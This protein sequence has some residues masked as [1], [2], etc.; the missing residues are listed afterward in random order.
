MSEYAFGRYGWVLSLTFLA[1]GTSSWALA[2]ALRAHIQTR[3]GRVGVTFLIV[4]GLGQALAAVFDIRHDVLH[5]LA[6][7]LG[8]IGLPVAAI[9]ISVSL[10]GNPEWSP[11]KRRLLVMA[12]L[13]W[14]SVVLFAA[15]FVLLTVTFIQ[16]NGG[17]PAQ[18]PE[19]LPP[20]VIGL[21]G[22]ANRFLV[23]VYC[24]WVAAVALQ[25]VRLRP[26]RR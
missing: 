21:V 9:L 12:N 24:A 3:G 17:L 5:N 23:I 20:G 1:W 13:T 6:G 7:A 8:I 15:A 26:N 11:V 16:V 14:I 22:W 10:G 19:V 25:T 2:F 4:A 18:P